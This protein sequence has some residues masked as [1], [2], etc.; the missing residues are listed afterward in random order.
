MNLSHSSDDI[1]K[2]YSTEISRTRESATAFLYPIL[3][4]LGKNYSEEYSKIIKTNSQTEREFCLKPE[5]CNMNCTQ[6]HL[7]DNNG[8]EKLEPSEINQ[9]MKYVKDFAPFLAVNKSDLQLFKEPKDIADGLGTYGCHNY[10]IP[11]IEVNNSKTCIKTE[12]IIHL[13]S[14]METIAL[15]AFKWNSNKNQNLFLIYG[16]L[17]NLFSTISSNNE[18]E[19]LTLFSGHDDSILSLSLV[20]DL[21]DGEFPSF[22]SHFIF[23]NYRN[24]NT[25]ENY[26]RIIFD[27][28]DVTALT[29]F[30]RVESMDCLKL[31]TNLEL[32]KVNK[33]KAFIQ[34]KFESV[35]K[36]N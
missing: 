24:K 21:F 25:N 7:G 26:L 32:I 33:F 20:F 18:T 17:N 1:L 34:N 30:C 14:F 13:L 29:E 6:K 8:T 22:A 11:C 36:C 3:K 9:A 31:E 4:S 35:F 16:F 23:E 28:K 10:T 15:K 5:Y 2:A 19:K 27:G 12:N